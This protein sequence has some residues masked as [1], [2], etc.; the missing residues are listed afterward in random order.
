MRDHPLTPMRDANLV[1]VLQ[2]QTQRQGRAGAACDG[3]A[4]RRRRS[5][6]AFDALRATGC[7]HAIVD[8]VADRDLEAIGEAAADLPLITGGSGIALGP[9]GEFPPPGPARRRRRCRR[10]AG[11]RRG[12]GRA[13]RARARRR[14]S[15][16]VAYMRERAPVFAIDPLAAAAGSESP[17]RR[18]PGRHRCSASGRC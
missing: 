18:S 2:R 17:A 13:V 6:H 11:G 4:R 12:G 10:A 8:A 3:R 5:A 7:R 16:Q 1:R 14:R 9:A 15:A